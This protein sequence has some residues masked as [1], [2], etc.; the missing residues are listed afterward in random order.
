MGNFSIYHNIF[1]SRLLQLRQNAPAIGKV[2]RNMCWNVCEEWRV[3]LW[4]QANYKVSE[5]Q[6]IN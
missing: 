1:R 3:K 2:L 6:E 5:Q 4:I